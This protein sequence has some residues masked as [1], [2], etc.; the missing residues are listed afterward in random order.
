M[1]DHLGLTVTDL[2]RSKAFYKVALAPLAITLIKELSAEDTGAHAHAGFGQDGKP[3]FWIGEGAHTAGPVYIAF[4]AQRRS[5]V[6]AFHRAAVRAGGRDNGPP[7]PRPHYHPNYFGA[8]VLDP[9]GNNEATGCCDPPA[10]CA[11]PWSKSARESERDHSRH[12]GYALRR[13]H[14]SHCAFRGAKRFRT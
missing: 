14:L 11:I 9:D 10:N 3:S 8:F 1:L 7:G 4:V 12:P 13:R 2:A 5:D 6:E